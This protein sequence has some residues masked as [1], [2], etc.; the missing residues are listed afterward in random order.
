MF[1]GQSSNFRGRGGARNT[2]QRSQPKG[3]FA[4]GIWHCDCIPRLPAEHYKVKKEGKNHGR[5][6]HTCQQAEPN[7]CG[8]FLW[9]D[10]AKPREE[11]AVLTGSR[12]EPRVQEGWTAG[13]M[14]IEA[15][16]SYSRSCRYRYAN[17]ATQGTK[18]GSLSYTCDNCEEKTAV[19][20]A[21]V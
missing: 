18:D 5:W 17:D 19:A 11:A 9:D 6:F 21:T 4:D 3:V 16:E 14:R 7:R 10:D 1:R 8:F 13:R 12:T 2:R 20:T 15:P